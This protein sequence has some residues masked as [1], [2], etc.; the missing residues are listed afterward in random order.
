MKLKTALQAIA[1]AVDARAELANNRKVLVEIAVEIVSA[2][3]DDERELILQCIC[4]EA[5]DFIHC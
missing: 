5:A 1:V 3:A 4:A 2:L